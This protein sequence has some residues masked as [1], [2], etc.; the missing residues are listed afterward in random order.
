MIL[1]T[2]PLT[3]LLDSHNPFVSNVLRQVFA[4]PEVGQEFHVLA[5]VVDRLPP[6]PAHVLR[7]PDLG[8]VKTSSVQGGFDGVSVLVGK[9]ERLAPDLWSDQASSP[10]RPPGA[11][12]FQCDPSSF[13]DKVFFR[14]PEVSWTVELALANTLFQNGHAFTLLAQRWNLE[15]TMEGRFEYLRSEQRL[16]PQQTLNMTKGIRPDVN[17][18]DYTAL[19]HPRV[20]ARAMGN[21]IR[22]FQHPNNAEASMPAS[23]E[24]EKAVSSEFGA[25]PSQKEV[26]AVVIPS[27]YWISEPCV[28]MGLQ[29]QLGLGA[30]LHRVLSGGGGYGNKQGLL[31]LDPIPTWSKPEE[32]ADPLIADHEQEQFPSLSEVVGPGDVISF[33]SFDKV[34][35]SSLSTD[36]SLEGSSNMVTAGNFF[37]LG[38]LPSIADET[39]HKYPMDS[40]DSNDDKLKNRL[41][42]LIAPQHFGAL[43]EKGISLEITAPKAGKQSSSLFKAGTVSHSKL[44]PG[45]CFRNDN[46]NIIEVD[47]ALMLAKR[48]ASEKTID[49]EASEGTPEATQNRRKKHK[50]ASGEAPKT[51]TALARNTESG[52]VRVRKI[53]HNT[54]FP[55]RIVYE[56]PAISKHLAAD[57]ER[58]EPSLRVMT[59]RQAREDKASSTLG[60]VSVQDPTVDQN[61]ATS[62]GRLDKDQD[63]SDLMSSVNAA[64]AHLQG[65][66]H[67]STEAFLLPFGQKKDTSSI[68]E[69]DGGSDH[70]ES[71]TPT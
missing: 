64:E 61:V 33:I 34:D 27:A 49:K 20:V 6:P 21:I 36:F 44:P 15:G 32:M 53:Q 38:S 8:F 26:W 41:Q 47:K 45:S 37:Q 71:Q 65:Q 59:R 19:T 30:R 3:N 39:H 62:E 12:F 56:A 22:S 50:A 16:L 54:P 35:R 5:A 69:K 31:S 51:S 42:Y 4:N 70:Q 24:L 7:A 43:S 29:Q 58:K 9:S 2:S 10:D 28:P 63:I 25:L 52:E 48:M 13:P 55:R 14:R 68:E 66:S 67:E 11:L 40:E 17:F 60:L 46:F 1:V 23:Q 57:K 18:G